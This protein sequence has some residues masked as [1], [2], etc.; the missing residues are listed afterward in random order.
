MILYNCHAF[1]Y[2][3]YNF[4]IRVLNPF[5]II[6]EVSGISV[7]ETVTLK[8]KKKIVESAAWNE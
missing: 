1:L 8:L 4:E 6:K 5:F 2:F 7:L 3:M